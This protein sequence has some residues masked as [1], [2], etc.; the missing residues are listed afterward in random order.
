MARRA[1]NPTVL[2]RSSAA[3]RVTDAIDPSPN[4]E[5]KRPRGS[6]RGAV[7]LLGLLLVAT[8]AHADFDAG[9]RA[10]DS[11][12]FVTAFNEWLPLARSGDAAAQR[13]LAHLYRL[14]RGVPQ[15][16]QV[17]ANWYRQAADRG[18]TRAGANLATMYLRGQGVPQNA[19]R[20]AAWFMRA[21]VDG[22]AIAQFNLA[23]MYDR[24]LGVSEDEARAAGWAQLAA[25]AGHERALELMAGYR[26]RNVDGLPLEILRDDPGLSE[27]RLFEPDTEEEI[28]AAAPA[29]QAAAPPSSAPRASPPTASARTESGRSRRSPLSPNRD[30]DDG[31]EEDPFAAKGPA[32]DKPAE[33]PA[34]PAARSPA[35]P[36]TAAAPRSSAP[37]SPTAAASTTSTAVAPAA[38]S[39]PRPDPAGDAKPPAEALTPAPERTE[40]DDNLGADDETA[41]MNQAA[42]AAPTPPPPRVPSA[43]A[44]APAAP[45]SAA[46]PRDDA[47]LV[48]EGLEAYRRRDFR[49]AMEVWL[50]L[51]RT[52]SA[53]AQFYV[54][55]L[56]MD[57]SGVPEDVVQAHAWWKLASE[58]DHARAKEFLTLVKSV[59]DDD[60]IKKSDELAE[61]LRPARRP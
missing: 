24:G 35:P 37:A 21:A 61:R 15:D 39:P 42:V 29:R 43:A 58:Q 28:A 57:G 44:P 36:R 55:G 20:A 48:A 26:D 8:P 17:A 33:A 31:E 10:Y 3:E 25:E 38:P 27:A 47:A 11:G 41:P 45:R 12:D 51:A 59:M 19:Q 5:W 6:H 52:G 50:P 14:G 46:L 60:Q 22:H 54:G 40:G 23:L 53:D 49:A 9:V 13:N 7:L 18:L 2:G 30:D 32:A 56:Y 16:F 34:R 1:V 4:D